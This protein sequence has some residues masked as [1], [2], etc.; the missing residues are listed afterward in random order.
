MKPRTGLSIVGHWPRRSAPFS[1][2]EDDGDL[3]APYTDKL[4]AE[5]RRWIREAPKPK[6][7]RPSSRAIRNT[8]SGT[9]RWLESKGLTVERL[10]EP[11]D[12]AYCVYAVSAIGA[13]AIKIG[14]AL[15]LRKRM[16][17]LAIGCPHPVGVVAMIS[18]PYIEDHPVP[19]LETDLHSALKAH[20]IRGEWFADVQAVRDCLRAATAERGGIWVLQ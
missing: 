8:W 4:S 9:A 6:R 5:D 18:T 17:G 13:R 20:R 3:P 7:C 2:P 15:N 10:G 19:T 16:S 11:T 14:R 12:P 1:M